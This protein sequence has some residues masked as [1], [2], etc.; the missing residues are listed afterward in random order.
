MT[1]VEPTGLAVFSD[2]LL[3][4]AAYKEANNSSLTREQLNSLT[5]IQH[6]LERRDNE[7]SQLMDLNTRL[8]AAANVSLS[9]HPSS[10]TMTIR[11]ENSLSRTNY[12]ALIRTCRSCRFSQPPSRC[13]RPV[14]PCHHIED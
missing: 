3:G 11:V 7:Y 12:N 1:E 13:I 4:I 2:V 9:F 6:R 5:E 10:D 8:V 14:V